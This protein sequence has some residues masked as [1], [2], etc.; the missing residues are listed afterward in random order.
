[1]KKRCFWVNLKNK[2]YIDYH[3][4]EWWK[5]KNEVKLFEFLI[6]EGQQAWLSWEIIL[7]KREIY[8][9]AFFLFDV[10]KCANLSD[11]DLE[12]ILKI[13]GII[14]NKNKIFSVRQN[15][16]VFLQIQK[17]FGSFYAYI[18]TF[19][20]GKITNND[21][22]NKTDLPVKSAISEQI[23][24][25]LK[26]RWAKFVWPVIIYSFLQATWFINDHENDCFCKNLKI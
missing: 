12:N 7:N 14:K 21:I 5:L 11:L 25:N 13:D 8:K 16:K 15:A 3:D 19:T 9:K 22:K 1:M 4:F 6:L 10:E 18:N 20:K 23:S 24:A 2:K 17:E 26:K